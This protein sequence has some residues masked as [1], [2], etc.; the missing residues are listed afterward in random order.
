MKAAAA[1]VAV[2]GAGLAGATCARMLTDAGFNVQLFDKSRGVG[3]R[4]ATRRAE[5]TAPDSSLQR[6][7]FDHGAPG[8]NAHSQDFCA[9][10][11]QAHRDGLLARWVPSMAPGSYAPLDAPALWVPVPDM[12]ALCRAIAAGLPLQTGCTVDGLRREHGGWCLLSA[13]ETVS[14]E[15]DAVVLALPPPQA[16][17]L[18]APHQL[19]WAQRLQAMPM[20]PGWTL[21]GTTT[22]PDPGA[23][24]DAGWGLGW[25]TS[26]PL[27]WVVRNDAKPGRIRTPGQAQWVLHATAAWSHTH[28]EAPA[29]EVQAALQQALAVWLGR[30]LDWQ[31]VA[32]HRWR[33]A[34]VPRAA[35]TPGRC[36]WDAGTGLGVC[37]DALGG[38]GVEGAWLSARALAL[39]M[40]AAP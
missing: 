22:E 10:V 28:L 19:A 37:G 25:P 36:W 11:E 26:G 4:L 8:F 30:S 12:P 32:V 31:H 29:A 7:N 15:L 13:G 35:A 2:L 39:A 23:N 16:A 1:R 9:F 33:Y 27:A 14:T 38:A 17:A 5:W 24:T 34:S 20:L 21:M 18:L 3:G 6:A 40:T